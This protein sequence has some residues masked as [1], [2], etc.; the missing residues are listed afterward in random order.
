MRT[1]QSFCPRVNRPESPLLSIGG[2]NPMLRLISKSKKV[3]KLY[4]SWPPNRHFTAVICG[5]S[6]ADHIT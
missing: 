4:K 5:E 1:L 2:G 3:K 6:R